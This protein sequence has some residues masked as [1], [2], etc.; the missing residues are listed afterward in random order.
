MPDPAHPLTRTVDT[1][2]ELEVHSWL[3]PLFK[4]ADRLI[5]VAYTQALLTVFGLDPD[6]PCRLSVRFTERNQLIAVN[7]RIG[8]EPS[9]LEVGVALSVATQI[10][11]AQ[12]GSYTSVTVVDLLGERVTDA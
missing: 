9:P 1:Q 11:L 4:H 12:K 8:R 6:T 2:F 7:G 5:E 10:V 3:A